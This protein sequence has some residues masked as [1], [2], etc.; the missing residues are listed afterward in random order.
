MGVVCYL[1]DMFTQSHQF[2]G[3]NTDLEDRMIDAAHQI[4]QLL[5]TWD[6]AFC[7][8]GGDAD[9]HRMFRDSQGN[10]QNEQCEYYNV[11]AAK[12]RS[13]ISS[14]GVVTFSGTNGRNISKFD[15]GDLW[16][17]TGEDVNFDV[18]T[19]II[20]PSVLLAS[21]HMPNRRRM[22]ACGYIDFLDWHDR[23]LDG[24]FRILSVVED[25]KTKGTT[26]QRHQYL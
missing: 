26:E 10:R 22:R 6:S 24:L 20:N 1:N 13:I 14:Y 9:C 3:G 4:G 17:S 12:L 5:Q 23:Y 25:E 2:L 21:A 7:E 16:H 15:D 19:D 11:F 18:R 8:L